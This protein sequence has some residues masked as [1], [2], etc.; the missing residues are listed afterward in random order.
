[1]PLFIPWTRCIV[2]LIFDVVQSSSRTAHK[3]SVLMDKL[4]EAEA[5]MQVEGGVGGVRCRR[6]VEGPVVIYLNFR[7][8]V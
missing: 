3:A 1:M 5:W 2:T 7:S 4:F 8:L 6:K